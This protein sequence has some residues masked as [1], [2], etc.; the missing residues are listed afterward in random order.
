MDA[1]ERVHELVDQYAEIF[2]KACRDGTAQP[3]KD[4]KT[5]A[6]DR[7]REGRLG[8]FK[9]QPDECQAFLRSVDQGL[10]RIEPDGNFWAHTARRTSRNLH[11][12]GRSGLAMALHTEYLIQIGA[13]AELILDHGWPPEILDFECGP[14]DVEGGEDRITLAVEAKAR[15]LPP[16]GDTLT[17]I[18]DAFMA[19]QTDPDYPMKDNHR[20]KW[21]RLEDLTSAGPV[22]LWLVADGARWSYVAKRNGERLVLTESEDPPRLELVS[23]LT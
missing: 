17:S 9:A 23:R 1:V 6:N 20:R 7:T 3:S 18:R 5:A 10:V 12:V 8:S 19:R 22:W 21:E 14:F 4:P 2:A 15:V 11:L 16:T 13:Y